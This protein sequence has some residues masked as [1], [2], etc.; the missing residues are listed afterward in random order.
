LPPNRIDD[1]RWAVLLLY[2]VALG[3]PRGVAGEKGVHVPVPHIP[4]GDRRLPT[5]LSGGS[6]AIENEVGVLVHREHLPDYPELVGRDVDGA[7]N[8]ALLELIFRP[9]IHKEKPLSP[10]EQTLQLLGAQIADGLPGWR[11]CGTGRQDQQ[12][13]DNEN[14]IYQQPTH[15]CNVAKKQANVDR[16]GA[17][18]AN[19]KCRYLVG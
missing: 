1:C 14:V 4:G 7:G 18:A 2:A 13:E 9:R 3:N 10:V 8:M 6:S 19:T 16:R 17:A 11:R 12:S 5:R 15:S